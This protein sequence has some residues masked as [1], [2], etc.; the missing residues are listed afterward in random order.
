MVNRHNEASIRTSQSSP[1]PIFVRTHFYMNAEHQSLIDDIADE[2]GMTSTLE[3]WQVWQ[4]EVRE[5]FGVE[6]DGI[7]ARVGKDFHVITGAIWSA[8]SYNARM[9]ERMNLG[10]LALDSWFSI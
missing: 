4:D 7:D 1:R 3:T 6:S 5:Y 9:R 8:A 2:L 10:F